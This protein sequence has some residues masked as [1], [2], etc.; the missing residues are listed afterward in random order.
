MNGCRPPGATETASFERNRSG[1]TR[2]P[3]SRSAS[4]AG[5]NISRLKSA[6][7]ETNAASFGSARLVFR[8]LSIWFSS[9]AGSKI[10]FFRSQLKATRRYSAWVPKSCLIDAGSRTIC[11]FNS[12]RS[13]CSALTRASGPVSTRA[14]AT[15]S[16]SSGLSTGEAGWTAPKSI[17]RWAMVAQVS[18]C[19]GRASRRWHLAARAKRATEHKERLPSASISRKL[20][21]E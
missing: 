16:A 3:R 5:L 15:L 2:R 6:S 21:R 4:A 17:Q 19:A 7:L 20:A 1:I 14:L 10:L 9:R 11:M 13:T 8:F 12:R 18:S